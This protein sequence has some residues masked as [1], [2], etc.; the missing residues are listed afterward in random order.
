MKEHSL[1]LTEIYKT[2][3]QVR[4]KVIK[5]A[6]SNVMSFSRPMT[7]VMINSGAFT[8]AEVGALQGF[9]EF[10]GQVPLLNENTIRIVDKEINSKFVQE[11]IVSWLKDKKDAVVSA[12]KSGWEGLKKIWGNFKEFVASCVQSIKDAFKKI[13]DAVLEKVQSG[14]GWISKISADFKA[15]VG[16]V[17]EAD[18][19]ASGFQGFIQS[20]DNK[21]NKALGLDA[22]KF[23]STLADDIANNA[24]CVL[25]IKTVVGDI[26]TGGAWESKVVNG[27]GNP[28]VD[29]TTNESIKKE[30]T[31]LFS[32]AEVMLEFRSLNLKEAGIEHPEDVIK[33]AMGAGG[34]TGKKAG[35]ALAAVVKVVL[36]ILKYTLGIFSTI[37]NKVGAVVAKNVFKGISFVSNALKG[38]G[39]F[40]MIALGFFVGE[41]AEV[42]AHNI[43]DIHKLVETSIDVLFNVAKVAM[44]WAAPAL[45][46]LQSVVLIVGYI[47]YYYAIATII[48][49]TIVPAIKV[50]LKTVK[51]LAGKMGDA[52]KNMAMR[53]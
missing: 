14:L 3:R 51:D 35:K 18:A 34:E 39:T 27:E 41:L 48:T 20:I 32:N 33:A 38:P 15:A 46:I 52:S 50:W 11:G 12:L 36:G 37:V 6:T 22:K 44:P 4:R 53:K 43:H 28:S 42:A 19:D 5:E 47:F 9:F 10:R 24:E 8:K 49:N 40:E 23:H 26:L 13:S 2:L 16:G 45:D 30:L 25:H 7:E 21:A 17:Q 31:T 29:T 1:K